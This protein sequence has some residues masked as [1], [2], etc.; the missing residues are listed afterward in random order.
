MT[1]TDYTTARHRDGASRSSEDLGPRLLLLALIALIL[2]APLIRGGY[3]PAATLTLQWIGLVLLIGAAWQAKPDVLRASE[4]IFLG[5]LFFAPLLYLASLPAGL[6]QTLPGRDLYAQAELLISSFGAGSNHHLT[7][8]YLATESSWLIL[9]VPIGVYLAARTL[10]EK[11]Q[12]LLVYAFF[13]IALAQMLIG[14]FQFATGGGVSYAIAELLNRAGASGTYVN[15]NH[16]A[17]MLEMALPLA[18]ALSLHHLR[19]APQGRGKNLRARLLALLKAGNR[20]SMIMILLAVLFT[21]GVIVTRSRTGILMAM[22]GILLTTILFSRRIGGQNTLGLVGQFVTISIGLAIFLGLAPVLDRFSVAEL[23]TDARWPIAAAT[24]D[25]AGRLLP[26]GAGPGTYPH[27]FVQYQPAELAKYFINY[28]HNDYLQ[29]LFEVG[30]WA[31][32]LIVMFMILYIAQWPRLVTRESWS[33]FRSL[34]IGAGVGIL[35]LLLHSFTDNNLRNPANM[36]YFALLA[37][38][39]FS[40]PG[41]PSLSGHPRKPKS[42]TRTLAESGL[43]VPGKAVSQPGLGDPV[44]ARKNPFM[45]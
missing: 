42:R 11:R 20:P 19:V 31:P 7:V 15:R 44:P 17:G 6:A 36:A 18:L 40:P 21:I 41:R 35:M 13:T 22:V 23:D 3:A 12:I 14:L 45:D 16:L 10:D 5:L 32:L 38:L 25:A 1:T 26:F 9:L 2:F 8:R 30:L 29:A 27:A 33:R 28:A 34:Q 24:F 37:A 43:S 39:F 4:W